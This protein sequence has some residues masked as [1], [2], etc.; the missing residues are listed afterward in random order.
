M[1]EFV[2]DSNR[3][4]QSTLTNTDAEKGTAAELINAYLLWNIEV[5]QINRED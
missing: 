3:D 1:T 4:T 2:P 5:F